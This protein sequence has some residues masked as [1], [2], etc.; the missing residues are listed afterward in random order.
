MFGPIHMP[1]ETVGQ[2]R[3]EIAQE[4]GFNCTYPW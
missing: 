3:R 2:L 4:V 1:G